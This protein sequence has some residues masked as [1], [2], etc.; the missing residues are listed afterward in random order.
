MIKLYKK[1]DTHDCISF[2]KNT[3]TIKKKLSHVKNSMPGGKVF[4]LFFNSK[5]ISETRALNYYTV[6]F[7]SVEQRFPNFLG[8]GQWRQSGLKYGRVVDPGQKNFDFSR[9]ISEKFRFSRQKLAIY[10]YSWANYSIAL[11]KS[12]LLNIFP[13]GLHDKI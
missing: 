12:P 6:L 8:C 13:V 4:V 10:S 11:Q 7:S 2:E 1:V 3:Q 9:K 5:L